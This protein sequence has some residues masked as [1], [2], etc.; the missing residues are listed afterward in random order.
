MTA[1]NRPERQPAGASTARPEWQQRHSD[2]LGALMRVLSEDNPDIPD[3]DLGMITAQ[4]LLAQNIFS[5]C[6]RI[7]R[8]TE[9]IDTLN[10]H[11]ETTN[12]K[13]KP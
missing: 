9:K 7:D 11:M 8:L 10:S 2:T 1:T 6:K 12:R 4:T 3:E 5:L 13:A